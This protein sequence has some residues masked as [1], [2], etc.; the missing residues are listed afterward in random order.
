M[1]EGHPL[2]PAKRVCLPSSSH[3]RQA[4]NL[5]VPLVKL[6][7]VP[8]RKDFQDWFDNPEFSDCSISCGFAGGKELRCHTVVLSASSPVLRA[9]TQHDNMTEGQTGC[10]AI[11]DTT[12]QALEA[13]LSLMYGRNIAVLQTTLPMLYAVAHQYQVDSVL[14]AARGA[15]LSLDT[16]G[17]ETAIQFGDIL[18]PYADQ[19]LN[20]HV[21]L[22]AAKK[23]ASADEQQ[24]H[25]LLHQDDHAAFRLSLALHWAGGDVAKRE[26]V[27]A[28]IDPNKLTSRQMLD[29]MQNEGRCAED[30]AVSALARLLKDIV[31]QSALPACLKTRLM[32]VQSCVQL[33]PH[34]LLRYMR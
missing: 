31:S 26:V 13:M 17:L 25:D 9:K 7:G 23:L 21:K 16:V 12:P 34:F 33:L 3:C 27:L 29:V 28:Y 18:M 4:D 32:M 11:Q 24:I 14:Q 20:S 1:S 5:E 8:S 15:V 22:M 19:Q 10:I 30:M 2:P 6:T